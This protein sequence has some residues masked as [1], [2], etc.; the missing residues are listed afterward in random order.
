MQVIPLN[1]MHD[2]VTTVSRKGVLLLALL[3]VPAT[4]CAD[5]GTP[6]M[7]ANLFHLFFGNLLIGLFEGVLTARIF[8][9]GYWPSIVFLTGANYVSA[10]AG[11]ILI[12]WI[13]GT[14]LLSGH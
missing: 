6:L 13:S 3:L 8:R 10:A 4:A 1:S 12:V 7:W 14:G 2:R 9:T 11:K 5:A